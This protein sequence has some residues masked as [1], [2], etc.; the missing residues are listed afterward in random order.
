MQAVTPLNRPNTTTNFLPISSTG[1]ELRDIPMKASTAMVDGAAIGVEIVSNTTTGNATLMPA[2]GASGWNFIGILAERVASTDSDYATAGKL[3][4]V[5][6]PTNLLAEAEFKVG[7]GTFTAVD[8]N[9]VVSFHSDSASLAVD[10]AG[11]G[12]IITGYINSSRGRCNFGVAK[13]VTA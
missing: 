8:V 13:T 6:V 12:A 3:K 5:W 11:A 1:W 4:K 2:T 9:K 7:A 10:T